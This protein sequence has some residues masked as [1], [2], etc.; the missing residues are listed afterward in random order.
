MTQLTDNT[1]IYD[2][3]DF[4]EL[5]LKHVVRDNNV[6][7]LAKQYKMV[8]DDVGGIEIYRGFLKIAMELENVPVSMDLFLIKIKEAY[9]QG[10]LRKEQETQILEFLYWMYNEQP[11]DSQ[12]ILQHFHGLLKH[13]RGSAILRDCGEN[14]D[15]LEAQLGRLT[16]DMGKSQT[17]NQEDSVVYP[18][19][20]PVF[21]TV[22]ETFSTGFLEIDAV[23]DGLGLGELGMIIG[24]S[25]T[26][27][28]AVAVH[29]AMVNALNG[30]K[31]LYLSLEESTVNISNRLYANYFS[32][33]YS[34]LHHV[35]N[36]ASGE[37]ES[38]LKAMP[39]EEIETLK[40]I[41]LGP[42]KDKAPVTFGFLKNY[43]ENIYQ[44]EG[45]H[46][47]II[48]IDQLNYVIPTKESD[49]GWE[50]YEKLTFEANLFASHLIG[51]KH[52]FAVWLLH[53]AGGKM[54]RQ[55]SNAE[56]SGFKGLIR[57]PTLVMGI[58]KETPQDSTVHLFSLK[59]RHSRTFAF[60][61]F[62][63]LAYMRFA[64]MDKG[65][66]ARMSKEKE[67]LGGK[68]KRSKFNVP[69]QLGLK[70]QKAEK[71]PAPGGAFN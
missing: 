16:F 1:N 19:L 27:K 12:Y 38:K 36:G 22:R 11:L 29:A 26:G 7:N 68:S 67:I 54:R 15:K 70:F 50:N 24:Y 69:Q 9:S 28:T 42:L 47:D 30:A 6:L 4:L 51:G 3:A 23:A 40:N 57:T 58:G 49:A 13:R 62:A 71:L 61:Y 37:L 35:K 48:Y 20:T 64:A 34:D 10:V 60:D 21:K 63:D 14:I 31:V 17:D 44:T 18:F 66:E 65:G 8:P 39:P 33:N 43:L 5:V 41:R 56:I 25:G 53:Q 32:I 2:S 52:K 46:P 45:Y 55:F 59:N